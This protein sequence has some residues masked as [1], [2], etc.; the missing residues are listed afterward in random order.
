MSAHRGI[1][2]SYFSTRRDR[3][4]LSNA[5]NATGINFV[6]FQRADL[7]IFS[8]EVCSTFTSQRSVNFEM[9]FLCLQILPKNERKFSPF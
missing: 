3:K 6:P 7:H 5:Q 8:T 9:S 4:L 1:K 2:S